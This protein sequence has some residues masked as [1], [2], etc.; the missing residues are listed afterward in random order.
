MDNIS[1][2]LFPPFDEESPSEY[3]TNIFILIISSIFST[4]LFVPLSLFFINAEGTLVK[5]I[6]FE[7][8]KIFMVNSVTSFIRPTNVRIIIYMVI[9]LKAIIQYLIFQMSY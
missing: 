4:L 8:L 7:I 3:H 6:L 2:N 9:S 1:F 5:I